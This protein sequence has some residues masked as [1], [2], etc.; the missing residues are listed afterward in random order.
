MRFGAGDGG[1]GS[2]GEGKGGA[3]WGKGKRRESLGGKGKES[4]ARSG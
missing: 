2:V 1:V 4:R 3:T